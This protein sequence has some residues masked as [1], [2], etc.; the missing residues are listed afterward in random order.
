MKLSQKWGAASYNAGLSCALDEPRHRGT[1]KA[2]RQASPSTHGGEPDEE[3]EHEVEGEH[4]L[5]FSAAPMGAVLLVDCPAPPANL[6]VANFVTLETSHRFGGMDCGGCDG[7]SVST[8]RPISGCRACA[9]DNTQPPRHTL[10]RGWKKEHGH[11]AQTQPKA[12]CTQKRQSI[13]SWVHPKTDR[14]VGSS[15][16]LMRHG[17]AMPIR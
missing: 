14:E 9:I 2:F 4:A 1:G 13:R 3:G 6:V 15:P 10:L 7:P 17:Q 5:A 11:S 8:M 12:K 16:V